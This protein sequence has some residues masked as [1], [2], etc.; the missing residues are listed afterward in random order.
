MFVFTN[1]KR[2][3]F[4]PGSSPFETELHPGQNDVKIT[5]L[6]CG[7]HFMVWEKTFTQYD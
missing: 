1:V 7:E 6:G 4:L 3:I 5:P 2:C